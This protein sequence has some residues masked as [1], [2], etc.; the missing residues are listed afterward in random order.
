MK[1]KSDKTEFIDL[2][3]EVWKD[4][5]W[6]QGVFQISNA[7]RMRRVSRNKKPLEVPQLCRISEWKGQKYYMIT[8]R[9]KSQ[10]YKGE[11]LRND[12]FSPEEFIELAP[13]LKQNTL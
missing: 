8:N 4:V 12:H 13:E 9:G 10:Y 6:G 5:Q 7:G 2:P 3:N 11:Y 1:L